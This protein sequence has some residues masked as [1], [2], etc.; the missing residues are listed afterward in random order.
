MRDIFQKDLGKYGDKIT[1]VVYGASN[2]IRMEAQLS[3]LKKTW[4]DMGFSY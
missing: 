4:A 3:D 1:E 2:E